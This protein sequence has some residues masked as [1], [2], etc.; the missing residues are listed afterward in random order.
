[1]KCQQTE[2]CALATEG[3]VLLIPARGIPLA[4]HDPIRVV[5]GLQLCSACIKALDPAE[6]LAPELSLR[7]L[8]SKAASGRIPPDFDRAITAGIPL[9]SNEWRTLAQSAPRNRP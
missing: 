2:C 4:E 3:L 7:S 5:V 9:D 1:M 6:L 8:V